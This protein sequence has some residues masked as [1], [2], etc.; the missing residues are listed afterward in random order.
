[1]AIIKRGSKT[2]EKRIK[3]MIHT[4]AVSFPNGSNYNEEFLQPRYGDS[5]GACAQCVRGGS[6]DGVDLGA[7]FCSRDQVIVEVYCDPSDCGKRNIN[8][9][10]MTGLPIV[11]E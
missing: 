3:P 6:G 8:A 7:D 5:L 4:R 9:C 1:M 10:G 2:F 11:A